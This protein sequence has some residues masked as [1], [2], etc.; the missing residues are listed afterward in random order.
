VS[1]AEIPGLEALRRWI[2][3]EGGFG[4]P[5]RTEAARLALSAV[6]RRLTL[7]GMEAGF[8]GYSARELL[9]LA[10]MVEGD[11]A[12]HFARVAL[13]KAYTV[14]D[15]AVVAACRAAGFAPELHAWHDERRSAD[16]ATAM[17]L[18]T[19]TYPDPEALHATRLAV[20]RRHPDLVEA[21]WLWEVPD[22]VAVIAHHLARVA[23]TRGDLALAVADCCERRRVVLMADDPDGIL[24]PLTM[25][26]AV[27][28]QTLL[29]P[30]AG[31]YGDATVLA[32]ARWHLERGQPAP[33]IELAARIRGLAPE[34]DLARLVVVHGLLA[35]GDAAGAAALRRDILDPPV[36]DQAD[37]AI[38]AARPG[39]LADDGL[40]AIARRC[41]AGE[42]ERFLAALR[43]LLDR[44]RLDL[45]R[46]L[47]G[48]ADRFAGHPVLTQVFAALGRR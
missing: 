36:A 14:G 3:A 31:I 12:G 44:R 15:E 19:S 24:A 39:H 29:R 2:I 27:P 8:S 42:P 21:G 45:A 18:A 26:S 23:A 5:V 9:Q 25:A 7:F 11:A 37:L 13:S 33:A 43:L 38:A 30:F 41:G 47:A 20:A 17:T 28:P 48:E 1:S 6:I 10:V 16:R 34:S 35:N 40:A 46:T 4:H 22:G 32:A